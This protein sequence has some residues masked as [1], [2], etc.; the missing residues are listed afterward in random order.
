MK[1]AGYDLLRKGSRGSRFVISNG[2]LG[3]RGARA[4][5]RGGR[6][7]GASRPLVAGLFDTADQEHAIPDLIAAPNWLQV[8]IFLDAVPL[9]HRPGDPNSPHRILDL[10]RGLLLT[11]AWLD[12]HIRFCGAIAARR[13]FSLESAH[14]GSVAE[15]SFWIA[16][17]RSAPQNRDHACHRNP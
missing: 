2:F 14:S 13:P 3:V 10:R 15:S 9:T 1:E 11:D 17:A 7:V 6:W 8:R 4:I 5:H 12:G 16:V